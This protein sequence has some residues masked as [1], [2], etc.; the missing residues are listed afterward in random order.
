MKTVIVGAVA[1]CPCYWYRRQAARI[2]PR[3]RNPNH[4][5][6]FC[7]FG[8]SGQRRDAVSI[9]D[10]LEGG[11]WHFSEVIR[12]GQKSPLWRVKRTLFRTDEKV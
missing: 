8:Q 3:D 12:N 7:N 4:C 1:G 10:Q 2:Q 5:N 9:K 11:F 6:C